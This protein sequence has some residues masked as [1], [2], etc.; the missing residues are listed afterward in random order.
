MKVII[1]K[2]YDDLSKTAAQ[3]IKD[4][5]DKKK[6]IVLGFATGS[7]PVGTYRELIRMHKEEGLDFS[8]VTSYNLDEYVGLNGDHPQSYRYFMDNNLFN[9][10]NIDKSKTYVPDGV[11]KDMEKVCTD[12]EKAM[13]EA[14]GIDLQVLGIGLSGHIAFNEPDEELSRLTTVVSLSEET[15][16][17]NSRFFE[18]KDEVPRKAI[19]MGMSSIMK[20]KKILLL[21]NGEGKA[22]A[23]KYI[24]D[25]KNLSTKVPASL[26]SLH[27]DV[28]IICD[29][30]AYS[31]E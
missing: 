25:S 17:A 11:D 31:G 13:D 18:N 15:I 28:T 12:Y 2:N 4:E 21:A 10:V 3:I 5:M 27:P 26:L 7:T 1:E 23:L 8:N 24:I 16:E 29:E 9:H 14:G 30:A 6:N 22:K 20:A 19:T